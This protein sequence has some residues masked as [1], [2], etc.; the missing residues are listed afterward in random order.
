MSEQL[1]AGRTLDARVA[2]EVLGL[3][4]RE[5]EFGWNYYA[6][7][8][9]IEE[10]LYCDAHVSE[11]EVPCVLHYST[12]IAAALDVVTKSNAFFEMFNNPIR[13]IWA[14]KFQGMDEFVVADTA[15]LA[16]CL[17]ALKA[18]KAPPA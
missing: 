18:V 13:K 1:S 3:P 14:V 6:D 8:G 16:M 11:P 17:A 9:S 2:L 4:K 12:D 15:P 5:H 10:C 7:A